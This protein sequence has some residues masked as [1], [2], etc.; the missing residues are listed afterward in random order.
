[1][2]EDSCSSLWGYC[3]IG[4]KESKDIL[5]ACTGNKE[6]RLVVELEGLA[7][8]NI[9]GASTVGTALLL[10]LLLCE[11][12]PTSDRKVCVGSVGVIV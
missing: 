4:S 3:L 1:M 12:L 2:E 10:V 8:R 5:N 6:I 9:D 7:P 11:S